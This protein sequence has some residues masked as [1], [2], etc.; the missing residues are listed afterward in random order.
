MTKFGVFLCACTYCYLIQIAMPQMHFSLTTFYSIISFRGFPLG[1]MYCTKRIV[2][3]PM[4]FK[5][6]ASASSCWYQTLLYWGVFLAWNL[7]LGHWIQDWLTP[8]L[9]SKHLTFHEGK[10]K[11]KKNRTLPTNVCVWF[12]IW[13]QC[14]ALITLSDVYLKSFHNIVNIL[15]CTSADS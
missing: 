8:S 12:Y 3:N 9:C 13:R 4:S 15:H 7:R 1:Q 5:C 14:F 2:Q 10:W 11:K 6:L